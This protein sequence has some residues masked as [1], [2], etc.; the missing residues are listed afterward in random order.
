VDDAEAPTETA[1]SL[2]RT[3]RHLGSFWAVRHEPAV[4][5][6]HYDD[7][8]AD[9]EGEMRALARRLG[10]EVHE[11]AWPALV[12]AAGFDSMRSR[13]EALAPSSFGRTL[14][15]D[16]EQ[17]FRAGTSGQWR[18]L[19]D[20]ADLDRYRRRVRALVDPDLARWA[21]GEAGL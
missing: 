12:E 1:S 14:W 13:A 3:L 6:L 21:H 10:I 16:P 20:E 11:G 19:L 9:L 17:F 15:R 2:L 8:T 7:L 5:L 4:V 18:D